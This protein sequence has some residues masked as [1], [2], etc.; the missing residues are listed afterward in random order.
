M[1]KRCEQQRFDL[2]GVEQRLDPGEVGADERHVQAEVV[3]AVL[4]QPLQVLDQVA[5][6]EVLDD[7]LHGVPAAS[8]DEKRGA[9][10]GEAVDAVEGASVHVVQLYQQV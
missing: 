5:L 1:E 10:S 8:G 7:L 9:V 4:A 2:P 3:P 6:E